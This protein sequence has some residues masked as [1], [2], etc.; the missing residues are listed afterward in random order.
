MATFAN[1]SKFFVKVRQRDDL[2]RTFPYS[3]PKAAR[4]YLQQLRTQGFK[5]V[6]GQHEDTI[7]V[8]LRTKG[9]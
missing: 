3:A 6:L 1:R 2:Y 7:V 5:P 4:A 8:R 9:F